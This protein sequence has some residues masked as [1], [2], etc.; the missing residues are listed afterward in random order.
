RSELNLQRGSNAAA[1]WPILHD[2]PLAV[3]AA[4]LKHNAND[5]C[6][7]L[8]ISIRLQL[9]GE[10]ETRS[11]TGG[12]RHLFDRQDAGAVCLQQSDQDTDRRIIEVSGTDAGILAGR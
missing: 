10:I 7:R 2:C 1:T 6:S 8:R 4:T 9:P 5:V 3:N 12:E 11:R